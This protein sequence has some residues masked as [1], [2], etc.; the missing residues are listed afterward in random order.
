MPVWAEGPTLPA[1]HH[2][3][4][5]PKPQG[6][7][8]WRWADAYEQAPERGQ[9]PA[10]RADE[11]TAAPVPRE[12]ILAESGFLRAM[13]ARFGV[14]ACERDDVLQKCLVGAVVAVREG[15]RSPGWTVGASSSAG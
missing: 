2:R 13:L 3:R 7:G 8:L 12:A 1:P 11:I 10:P 5:Q 6:S 9:A 15:G 4:R 14:S